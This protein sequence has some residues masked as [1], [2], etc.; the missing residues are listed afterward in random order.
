MSD[1]S[2][3]RPLVHIRDIIAAFIACLDAPRE[4]IHDEAFNVGM[5]GENYRIRDVAEIVKD[6]V[7][8]LRGHVRCRRLA[9][10]PQLPGRLHEDHRD[11]CPA[12]QPTW[13]VRAGVEELYEAYTSAEL[14]TDEWRAGSTTA[15]RRQAPAGAR[16]R[17][18]DEPAPDGDAGDGDSRAQRH[19]LVSVS[20]SPSTTARATS[21]NP[22]SRSSTRRTPTSSSSS[23]TTRR[24]TR[25]PQIIEQYAAKDDRIRIYRNEVN[26]GGARNANRVF[27]LSTGRYYRLASHD[28]VCLP[29]ML[30]EFVGCSRPIRRSS[31]A[32]RR[33]GSSTSRASDPH[34][35]RRQGH[36]RAP[37]GAFPRALRPALRLRADLRPDADG[38][39]APGPTP[40]QL[41]RPDRVHA[42][43]ARAAGPVPRASRA[44]VPEAVPP[45]EPVRQLGGPHVVVQPGDKTKVTL[46]FWIV[47]RRLARPP[48]SMRRCSLPRTGARARHDRAAGPCATRSCS[49]S[50][51]RLGGRAAQ[52]PAGEAGVP[53]AE[54]TTGSDRHDPATA[55]PR[56]EGR[57]MRHCSS[58]GDVVE[59]RSAAEILA[60]LD[61][62]GPLDGDA[63]HAGDGRDVRAASHVFPACRQGVRH[64]QQ[65]PLEPPAARHG[66]P[67]GSALRRQRAR[68]LPGRVPHL[69][70]GGVA[71]AREPRSAPTPR[72][73]RT[74]RPRPSCCAWSPAHT[75]NGVEGDGLRY[76]CQATQLVEAVRAAQGRRPPVRTS[77]S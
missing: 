21:P 34:Q 49:S 58:A 32:T 61:E 24:P 39:A 68:R 20:A 35:R 7:P 38:R 53:E 52:P 6:V 23:A 75:T 31:C 26:I 13:T 22:S 62:R 36:G 47:L 51:R 8:G 44:A 56:P 11:R 25:R 48:C 69:L 46:P 57:A 41:R 64:D 50:R 28:D 12:F 15:C 10:H 40:R 43:R 59:V 77:G 1:G 66:V 3:W 4:A 73:R 19:P 5:N 37:V 27:E 14:T 55:S 70:E 60:T 72:R 33:S 45:Q 67:R 18:D 9:R 29:T 2:P 74:K 16:G 65:Q 42:V 54:L 76:R 17:I 71:A 30:E 63:V